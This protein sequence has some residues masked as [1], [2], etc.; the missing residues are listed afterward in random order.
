MRVETPLFSAELERA[1]R[2]AVRRRVRRRRLAGAALVLAL[3]ATA[4]PSGRPP[5][6]AAVT[7][8]DGERIAIG[9]R[10]DEPAVREAFARAGLELRI[11][12]L[13][14]PAARAGEVLAVRPP[15][16]V[17]VTADGSFSPRH[18]PTRL[19]VGRAARPG[20]HLTTPASLGAALQAE[21]KS[22]MSQVTLPRAAAVAAALTVTAGATASAAEL[23]DGQAEVRVTR[24]ADGQ[25]TEEITT[26]DGRFAQRRYDAAGRLTGELIEDGR[27]VVQYD[28]RSGR[29]TRHASDGA[30]H[31]NRFGAW[32]RTYR[33][34]I[35][36]GWTRVVGETTVAGRRAFELAVGTPPRGRTVTDFTDLRVFVD[37][38][39]WVPLRSVD[40]TRTL[41][42]TTSAIVP[43]AQVEAKLAPSPER[44]SLRGSRTG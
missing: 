1:L 27:T 3:L 23:P 33:A 29:V 8:P 31:D 14:V 11:V 2:A 44:R 7:L 4:L 15:P 42:E 28:P 25:R 10:L 35:E 9:P 41:M 13:P 17:P 19:F 22:S 12:R 26:A 24:S 37:A 38:V 32:E 20:E 40:G 6:L 34:Q 36:R 30:V 5:A 18:G 39:T 21:G 43:I 16:G